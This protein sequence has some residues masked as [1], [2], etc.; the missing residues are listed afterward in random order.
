MPSFDF[1]L[2]AFRPSLSV[3]AKEKKSDTA[4]AGR[5]DPH[6]DVARLEGLRKQLIEHGLQ[7]V[8]AT[9]TLTALSAQVGTPAFESK[10]TIVKSTVD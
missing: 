2:S 10:Y 4:S 1:R 6:S 7:T 8:K 5:G 3:A 9:K